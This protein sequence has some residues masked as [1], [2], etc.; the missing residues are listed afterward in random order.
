MILTVTLNPS[1]DEWVALP[2]LTVGA[3]NRGVSLGRYPGGK[4]INVS[5]VV[6]ELGGATVALGVAGGPDGRMLQ[7]RLDDLQVR[8]RLFDVDEPT[9]NNYKLLIGPEKRLTE[10]N[11]E[12]PDISRSILRRLERFLVSCRPRPFMAVLSGSLPPGAPASV[13]ARWIRRLAQRGVPV[14]L[15]ASGAAL[16][17]GASARPWLI[18]PNQLEAEEL[19]GARAGTFARQVDAAR[20]LCRLGPQHVVLSL[21]KDGALL[22]SQES[23]EVWYAR[24]PMVKAGSAVGAGDSL[25]AGLIVGWRKTRSLADAFRLGVAAGTATAMTPGTELCRRADV[26]RVLRLVTIRRVR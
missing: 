9:R 15:D 22:A 14:A 21:G 12:G 7:E 19:L 1:L 6:R 25:V 2:R 13:Y 8:H 5:R 10:I 24:P 18:K 17:L 3:L 26:E 20:R 16:R 23:S 11:T 4:G